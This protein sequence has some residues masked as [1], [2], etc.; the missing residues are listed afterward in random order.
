MVWLDEG[1]RGRQYARLIAPPASLAPWVEHFWIQQERRP[2]PQQP[3]RIVADFCGHL[4]FAIDSQPGSSE[5]IR[6]S[7]AG[8]R[9]VYAD[10]GVAR[11]ILTVGARLRIGALAHL[12]RTRAGV[13][14]GPAFQ[15]EDVFGSPGRA[16]TDRMSNSTPDGAI[17]HL[18][19]FLNEKLS[20]RDWDLQWRRATQ[21]ARS[22][23]AVADTLGFSLRT[24][25]TRTVEATGLSPRRLLR[26]MRLH[27]ALHYAAMPCGKWPETAYLA[28]FADQAHMVRE[29]R[30]LLGDSP[31]TWR[32]RALADSFNT[33][34]L[35]AR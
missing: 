6:C 15:A 19:A 26:I 33:T 22:V 8:S 16:L 20:A 25:Y 4:V 17:A 7:I 35:S 5:R 14:T 11:R 1:G 28:G 12:T 23:A 13:F 9:A 31:N 3:W 29:F 2:A 27:R 21:S 18:A 32:R 30:A 10:I 24:S 34:A